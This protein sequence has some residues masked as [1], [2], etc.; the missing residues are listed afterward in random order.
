MK[1]RVFLIGLFMLVLSGSFVL[2]E[3]PDCSDLDAPDLDP[4]CFWDMENSLINGRCVE[5]IEGHNSIDPNDPSRINIV[6]VGY[7]YTSDNKFESMVDIAVNGENAGLFT[8]EPFKSNLNRFNI[9]Y[10]DEVQHTNIDYSSITNI[11]PEIL[12]QIFPIEYAFLALE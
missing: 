2:A 8:L 12:F 4:E 9:W 6:F 5:V 3:E 11:F 7:D 1:K 10:V